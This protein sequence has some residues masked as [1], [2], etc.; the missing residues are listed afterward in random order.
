MPA[1]DAFQLQLTD[2]FE[3]HPDVASYDGPSTLSAYFGDCP[4]YHVPGR[5]FPVDI[6]Y[7]SERPRSYLET[8]IETTWDLHRSQGPGDILLFLTGQEE[9]ERAC[10][11]LNE[12]VRDADETECDDAQILPLYAALPPEAQARVFC[13][14]PRACRRIVVA[15]NIAETS[16]TVPGVVFVVDPGVVK[17]NVY[18]PETGC[19]ALKITGASARGTRWA[20]AARAVF[21]SVHERR[22]RARHAD[23]HRA[24]DSGAF[25][26]NV[27]HP[28]LDFNI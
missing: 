23:R 27:F 21:P 16:L 26:A 17:Q 15:T 5:V 8:A 12:R 6:A 9:I 13:A 3:R 2:A 25:Y 18:D 7:A 24:G 10:K 1:L 28:P 22:V 19:D 14:P 20:D 11:R 4:V